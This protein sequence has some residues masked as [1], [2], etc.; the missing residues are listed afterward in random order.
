MSLTLDELNNAVSGAAA[1]RRRRRLQPVEGKGAK[2]FPPTYPGER[3][4]DP[5]RHAF[6]RRLI[7]QKEVWCVLVDSVQSQANRLEECLQAAI[8]RKALELPHILLDLSGYGF[9]GLDRVTSLQAPHRVYD[10]I[11]RDAELNGE[12]FMK[13]DTGKKLIAARPAS[14]DAV[15]ELSPQALLLGAWNSTGDGGGFGAKFPR[16]M[17]SEL[18][19]VNVPVDPIEDGDPVSAARRTGSRIDPIGV[20]RKVEVFKGETGWDVDPKAAGKG[21]KKVRP[22]EINHGN[23]APSVTKLGVTCEYVD[24]TAVVSFAGIRRLRFASQEKSEAA[25]SVLAALG[26]VALFEQDA[27][28][29]A[30]RSRCDL[31]CDGPSPLQLVRF[32]GSVETI[33]IGL[34]ECHQLYAASVQAARSAGFRYDPSP[35]VLKPQKKLVTII[36]KS[37]ELALAGEGGET[38]EAKA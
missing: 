5:P 11:L 18:I 38:E 13:S 20:L 6:E 17:V 21:A 36:Q 35:L 1:I 22:S 15:F 30:L 12:P 23:I 25:H 32:D 19:G 31:V 7:D 10:A 4:D 27:L 24:Q 14:A 3:K 26:L 8:D 29:Y 34:A 16:C 37:R 28:G 2:V 33:E 9:E